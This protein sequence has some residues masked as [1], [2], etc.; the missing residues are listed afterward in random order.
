MLNC[1]V[2][3]RDPAGITVPYRL[4]VPALWYDGDGDANMANTKKPTWLKRG[5]SMVSGVSRRNTLTGRQGLGM[6][7][8]SGSGSVSGSDSQ[9]DRGK[10]M[11]R[12]QGN[13]HGQPVSGGRVMSEP[14]VMNYRQRA[15]EGPTAATGQ[16]RK[17][18]GLPDRY[19]QEGGYE[20]RPLDRQSMD[21]GQPQNRMQQQSGYV[22]R[23]QSISSEPGRGYSG[24]EAYKDKSKGWRKFF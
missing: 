9:S 3:Q 23:S 15:S 12:P 14:P 13:G 8:G 21:V 5:M 1:E 18:G 20:Q 4:L 22:Q 16:G 17:A 11:D 19:Q 7:A 2:N 6:W 24:I 10:A